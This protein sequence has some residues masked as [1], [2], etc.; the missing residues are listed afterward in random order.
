M[1]EVAHH[2]EESFHLHTLCMMVGGG[3]V[4]PL[5]NEKNL[6][7]LYHNFPAGSFP[8]QVAAKAKKRQKCS[9]FTH[10]YLSIKSVNLCCRI[11]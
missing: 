11:R 6:R 4:R 10:V 1:F 8:G 7:R 9:I 3:T 5:I 2:K